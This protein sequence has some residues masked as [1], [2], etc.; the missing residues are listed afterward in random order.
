M[1]RSKYKVV[2]CFPASLCL[3]DY[4]GLPCRHHRR[5]RSHHNSWAAAV[6]AASSVAA[7]PVGSGP[8]VAGFGIAVAVVVAARS[9]DSSCF[10]WRRVQS[11]VGNIPAVVPGSWTAALLRAGGA[12]LLGVAEVA[13]AA[14]LFAAA[15][16][17]VAAA[18]VPAIV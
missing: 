14:L 10:G 16:A 17:V 18:E 5:E 8:F 3:G 9:S 4:L 2:V 7:G 6:V 15:A 12:V 1:H 11:V 13:F